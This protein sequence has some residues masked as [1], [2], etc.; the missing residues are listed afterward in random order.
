MGNDVSIHSRGGDSLTTGCLKDKNK[1]S[2]S[3]SSKDFKKD[4]TEI[5]SPNAAATV[6]GL[7]HFVD[8]L[9]CSTGR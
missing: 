7:F 1:N 6:E 5:T 3:E 4:T 8:V 9:S 2:N